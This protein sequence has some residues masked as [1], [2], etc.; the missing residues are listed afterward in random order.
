MTVILTILKIVGI[1]IACILLFVLLLL[2]AILLCPIRYKAKGSY[3]ENI[4][5]KVNVSWLLHILHVS[6]DYGG[7]GLDFDVRIFGFAIISS[8]KAAKKAEKLARKEAKEAERLNSEPTIQSGTNQETVSNSDNQSESIASSEITNE[9]ETIEQNT[10]A[11]G[12][13]ND[14]TNP[15]KKTVDKVDDVKEKISGIIDKANNI[16]DKVVDV[17]DTATNLLSDQEFKDFLKLIKNQVI[18]LLKH[19]IPRKHHVNVRY[20]SDD[21]ASTGQ[22]TGYYYMAKC[23]LPLNV[24]FEPDFEKEVIAVDGYLKGYIRL[25]VPVIIALKI[26]LNKQFRRLIKIIKK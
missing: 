21:P 8:K 12:T 23:V 5:A 7:E 1:A 15:I 11:D 2:L 13:S 24:D 10:E 19:I 6:V 4:I 25:I 26:L 17:K 16:K 14:K 20:G 22:I 18:K 9:D 3:N